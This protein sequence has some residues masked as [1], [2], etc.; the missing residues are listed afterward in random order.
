MNFS[1]LIEK[2]IVWSETSLFKRP[3]KAPAIGGT[4]KYWN[5]LECNVPSAYVLIVTRN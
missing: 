3:A 2:G 5:V 4:F 1:V